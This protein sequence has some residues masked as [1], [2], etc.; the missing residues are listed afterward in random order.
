MDLEYR[1]AAG[2]ELRQDGSLAGTVIRYGEVSPSFAERFEPGAFGDVSA[3][4]VVLN[5]AHDRA[6]PLARTGG[7]GLTLE[8]SATELR[9]HAVLPETPEATAAVTLIKG[10]VLRGLSVEF[11]VTAERSEKGIRVV[12]QAALSAVAVVD[13][14]AYPSSSVA[15]RRAKAPK[16][17]LARFWL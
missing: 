6:R 13:S 17:G 4:D 5:V 16:P 8:D 7:G 10:R 11:R 15:A 14:P 1:F 9:L 12:E 2:L 3:S